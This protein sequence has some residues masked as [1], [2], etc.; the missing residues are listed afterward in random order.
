MSLKDYS[1]RLIRIWCLG[2]VGMFLLVGGVKWNSFQ[3]GQGSGN[4]LVMEV[5]STLFIAIIL[6]SLLV[7]RAHFRYKRWFGESERDPKSRR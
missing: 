7:L 6:P 4:S 3:N 2:V 1:N 5:V